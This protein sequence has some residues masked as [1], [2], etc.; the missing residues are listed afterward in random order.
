MVDRQVVNPFI[1]TWMIP[2]AGIGV[3]AILLS[4]IGEFFKHLAL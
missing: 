2:V 3:Y 1:P 4:A